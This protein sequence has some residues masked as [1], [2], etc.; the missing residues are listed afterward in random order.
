MTYGEHFNQVI[1]LTAANVKSRYRKTFAGFIWVVLNP[2]MMFGAQS[3]AFKTFLKIQVPNFYIFL[4]GGLLPW[5]FIIQTIDMTVSM[6]QGSGQ[7][8][9]SFKLHP[10]TLLWSQVLDNLVNFLFAFLILLIALFFGEAEVTRFIVLLPVGVL[11]LI[12]GVSS[13]CWYLSILQIFYKDVRYVVQFVTSMMFFLTPIF[14]PASYIPEQY[15]YLVNFNPFYALIEPI[16]ATIY[17]PS[18]E[19]ITWAFTRGIICCLVFSFLA[20]LN[21]R[22][23]KNDFYL[24]I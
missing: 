24:Q 6:L 5:I 22:T 19:Q 11:I 15:R 12:W 23:K 8:L 21:W 1:A 14:Y 10:L 20:I 7:I 3:L 18:E 16:R 17:N 4:L 13:M 2:I 9:K